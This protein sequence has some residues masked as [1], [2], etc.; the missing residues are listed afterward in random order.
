LEGEAG[1]LPVDPYLLGVWLGDGD[2]AQGSFTKADADRPVVDRVAQGGV[3]LRRRPTGRSVHWKVEGL[4]RE[5]KLAGLLRNKHIPPA[6][7]RAPFEQRLELLRGLMDTDGTATH[8]EANSRCEFTT[9]T[10]R[11]AE[12][13]YE[14]MVGLGLVVYRQ[15]GVAKLNGRAI[16]P[17]WRLG[18]TPWF[19]PF[20]L[21]RKAG[22]VP[23]DGPRKGL[24]KLRFVAGVEPA[25]W[26]FVR[27]ITVSSPSSLYLAGRGMIPTHNS[28]TAAAL[29][30]HES[31][32]RPG[33]VV[34][35]LSP[36]LRQSGELF[37]DKVLRLWRK[38]GSPLAG[39]PP[40]RTEVELANGSRVVSLPENEETIRGFSGVNLLVIDEAA[41]VSDEL[42]YAVRPML[43]VSRGRLVALS[44]PFGQRGWYFDAWHGPE[45][46]LRVQVPASDCPRI[47]KEFL[48][49][50]RRALGSRWYAME[51]GLEF[52]A[53]AGAV[54]DP[55]DVD[56]AVSP[57]VEPIILE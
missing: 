20:H 15:E 49:A 53:I 3:A 24:R 5:L 10:R 12:D 14:L 28:L 30:L 37:R 16:G 43:A 50:E 18:F 36:S 9:T 45:N 40:T 46:W 2:S 51:Y 29:A 23:F 21:A 52:L 48:E 7:L 31:L 42:Y 44:T 4:T 35:L 34:L 56:A 47:S 27:C 6:Y 22:R 38:L 54:F 13:A 33:A 17:K 19:Q 55:Q 41:R 11:L 32:T 26:A 25:G 1:D 39:R 8:R 57:D